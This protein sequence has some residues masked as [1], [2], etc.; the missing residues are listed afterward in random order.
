MFE[1]MSTLYNNNNHHHKCSLQV[2][3]KSALPFL[4]TNTEV[5]AS[6]NIPQ[7]ITF[8]RYVSNTWI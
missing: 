4:S 7:R 8:Q 6:Y 2:H 3:R 1:I 5:N